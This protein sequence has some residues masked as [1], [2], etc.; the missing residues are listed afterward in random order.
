MELLLPA[1]PTF[2]KS[3]HIP[4]PLL[5]VSRLLTELLPPTC[6]RSTRADEP[7]PVITAVLLLANVVPPSAREFPNKDPP[8]ATRKKLP[9]PLEPTVGPP[10]L[11]ADPVP[12]TCT[13]L[14]E[15]PAFCPMMPVALLTRPPL[16][17]IKVVFPPL[18]PTIKSPGN[19]LV[20]PS[21]TAVPP[22]G[23]N[24]ASASGRKQWILRSASS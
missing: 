16:V 19:E 14:D 15:L 22:S 21:T 12:T 2:T 11:Q 24:C 17:M 3:A 10:V 13:T 5:M 1:W 8:S 23:T 4:A 7:G 20:T 9:E 18:V 6:N